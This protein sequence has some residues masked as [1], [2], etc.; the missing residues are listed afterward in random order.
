[1]CASAPDAGGWEWDETLYLGSAA[2]YAKGR[3]PYQPELVRA[4]ATELGLDGT[5]RLLDCGCGPG[6]LTLLLAP[7]VAEA[8]G[9]DA[10]PDMIAEAGR[11]AERAS[12][13]NV[14]WRQ[15]RAE[16]LPSGLGRFR[17]VTFAQ[18]FHWV[19]QRV[20][21]SAVRGML[22]ANGAC[23]HV[24]ATTH[25]GEAG[26]DELQRPRPPRGRIA[27][28]IEDYLGPVRRAG[29]GVLPYGPPAYGAG[30][31]R[32]AGFTGPARVE[33]GPGAVHL[34]TEE[35]IVASV[36][37]LSG[38]APHLFGDRAAEFERDLRGLLRATAADGQF[39]ERMR[40]T[41]FEVWRAAG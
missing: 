31:M 30:A 33:V 24:L 21:A 20:V 3:V 17:A 38:A 40:G 27:G 36:F 2:Y 25:E 1:M 16:E 10:D 34:R 28:L 15:L 32:A 4:L 39:A 6:S 14:S 26:D 29:Q 9:I 18:S 12:I 23:V 13:D 7:L 11:A 37:S 22:D 19:D 8:V 5:G 41:A 35:E